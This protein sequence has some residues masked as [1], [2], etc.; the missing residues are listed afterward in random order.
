VIIERKAK[1]N[2]IDVPNG[3]GLIVLVACDSIAIAIFLNS[4]PI[5]MVGFISLGVQPVYT[6]Q[7]EKQNNQRKAIVALPFELFLQI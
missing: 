3:S 4:V 5:K 1:I 7:Q 2:F 6:G